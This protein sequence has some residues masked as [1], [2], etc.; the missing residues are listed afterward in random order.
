MTFSKL[1]W[2]KELRGCDMKPS[3]YRVL[4]TVFDY[5]DENGQG[6][7]PGNDRLAADTC[8]SLSTVKD[9]LKDLVAEG[10]LRRE[11]RGGRSGSG[12]HWAAEYAL[13]T[14]WEMSSG[15][16]ESSTGEFTP[17]QPVNSRR[18]NSQKWRSQ[19]PAGNPPPD[20]YSPD[21]L[22]DHLPDHVCSAHG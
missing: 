20:H 13:T 6:A 17:C 5:T 16:F 14:P 8:L 9:A 19:Q 10:W 7:Y 12:A 18:V 1:L 11:C 15:E 21:Q 3:A 4:M 2:H 22:S